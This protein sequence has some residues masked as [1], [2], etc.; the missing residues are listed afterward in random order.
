MESVC[1]QII[2]GNTTNFSQIYVVCEIREDKEG[3]DP[4]SMR[5]PC[6]V[7]ICRDPRWV[8]FK[9]PYC[10]TA[11]YKLYDMNMTDKFF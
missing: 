11:S 6:K 9:P 3:S 4:Q 2:K 10:L 7:E 8:P 5:D 1:Q